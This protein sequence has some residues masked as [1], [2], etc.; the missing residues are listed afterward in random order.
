MAYSS[1]V[2]SSGHG[3]Y[4]RGACGIIDEVDEARSVTERVAN[5]LRMRGV[6]VLTFHD[7]VSGSQSENLHRITDFHNAHPRDLDISIHFNAFEQVDKPMGVEVLYITQGALAGEVSAAIA[8][9]GGF[10]NRG[11]KKRTDLHFLNACDMAAILLEVCF[12]DSEAD[13]VAYRDNFEKIC[14]AIADAIS[15]LTAADLEQ[16]PEPEVEIMTGTC[17]HFG[18]PDDEGVSPSEGLAFIHEIDERNQFLFLPLQPKGTT[19]LARRLN[20]FVHY[21][22]MRWDY[23]VHPKETLLGK[24]ALVRNLKTGAELTCVP[25]DWGPHEQE[26][27]RLIDLS[28]SMMEDLRLATDDLVEVIFPYQG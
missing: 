8:C 26:T 22:A 12:V 24:L 4:V 23:D 11:A 28:P 13:C 7:D 10:L 27:G 18:G 1:I 14:M 6:D 21:C 2:I 15:G 25:A 3:K 9:A 19:G 17:S 20:P 16:A 5:D